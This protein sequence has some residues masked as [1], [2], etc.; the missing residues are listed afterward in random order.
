LVESDSSPKVIVKCVFDAARH[1]T[2]IEISRWEMSFHIAGIREVTPRQSA[3]GISASPEKGQAGM[4]TERV[5]L[6]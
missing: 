4:V 2:E 5:F 3:H 6:K 1:W